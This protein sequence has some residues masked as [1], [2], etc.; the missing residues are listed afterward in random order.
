MRKLM[1]L[2]AMVALLGLLGYGRGPAAAASCDFTVD[3][4]SSIQTAVDSAS[5]GDA[6]CLDDSAGDF[7]QN[8]V[9]SGAA[10]SGI[11]LKPEP[12]DSP[13]LDGGAAG[14]GITLTGGVTGVVIKGLTIQDYVD[15]IRVLSTAHDN[16]IRENIVTNNGDQGVEIFGDSNSI[17]LN[18]ITS[19]GEGIRT[20]VGSEGNQIKRNFVCSNIDRDIHL[21]GA[22]SNIRRN[23]FDS[24][25][26]G[27]DTNKIDKNEACP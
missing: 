27:T 14:V 10:D 4:N 11:T 13:V 24:L 15:G 18:T 5:D 7:N 3:K 1:I 19:N 26:H 22:D 6:V 20:R 2:A 12:H 9:F 8:V 17:K 21:D 23:T 25:L 16:Q